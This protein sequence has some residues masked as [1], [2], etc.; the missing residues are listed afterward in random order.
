VSGRVESPLEL[1]DRSKPYHIDVRAQAGPT[2]AHAHGD[3]IG[4]VQMQG[5]DLQFQLSGPNLALLYPLTGVVT[6]DTPPYTLDGR[7]SRDGRTWRYR[8]FKGKVGDSDLAGDAT[9]DLSGSKPFLKADLV[10]RRLD[11]DDLAGFVGAP[12]QTAKGESASPEQLQEAARLRAAERVLPQREYDL[13]RLRS[14][15]ADVRLRAQRIEAPSLPLEAMDAHLFLKDGVARLDPLEFR[16]AGGTVHSVIRLDAS[17]SPIR[18]Q[19]RIRARGLELPKLLPNAE[20]TKD[21]IGRIGG[22]V[23]LAGRGNSVAAML[24]SSDGEVGLIMGRGR[25]SNLLLEYAGIDIAEAVKF[26]LTE[27]KVVPVRCAF[28]DF[29][30]QDGVMSSRRL[31]FDTTDTVIYGEGSVSLRDETLDLTLKPQPKDRS[32]LS[33]RAPL[34]VDGSFKDPGFH[35]D[36][37]RVTLRGLAAAVL[38]S[39]APPAALL[40]VYEPGPGKDVACQSAK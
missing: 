16:A 8:D 33:L 9:V 1:K 12:P 11:F 3:L 25:I 7:L 30:V 37:K 40:A 31:A 34:R 24:G 10:S 18:S 35:P 32:F 5:F 2:R 4:P 22:T 23:D 17:R 28:A 29:G 20:I 27:D 13:D 19:A 15:D 21:S 38:G 14:M 36:L 39:L 26:L 6:P